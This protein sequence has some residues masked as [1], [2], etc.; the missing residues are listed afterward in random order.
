MY[1]Y[2]YLRA[3]VFT[4]C[5]C[6]C[7]FV[8]V[9]FIFAHM[10]W[11]YFLRLYVSCFL[12]FN[13]SYSLL[14]LSKRIWFIMKGCTISLLVHARGNVVPLNRPEN[15]R[16]ER[17]Q[18]FFQGTFQIVW[19]WPN[20]TKN[21]CIEVFSFH[22]MSMVLCHLV[23]F[24]YFNFFVFRHFRPLKQC[25]HFRSSIKMFQYIRSFRYVLSP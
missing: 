12:S 15:V 4:I 11:K 25:L 13:L 16:N 7:V 8:C 24:Q 3:C 1:Y 14:V 6:L 17:S 20:K 18:F 19:K 10:N 23:Y 2:Y 22:V 21:K 9:K 5:L